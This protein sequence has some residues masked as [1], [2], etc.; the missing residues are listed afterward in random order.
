MEALQQL[1]IPLQLVD[2]HQ[3]RAGCVGNIRDK[4]S[5]CSSQGALMQTS[6]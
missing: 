3:A 2:V 4:Y 6:P 5:T 1:L